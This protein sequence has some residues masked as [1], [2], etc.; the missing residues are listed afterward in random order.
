MN[1]SCSNKKQFFTVP[2]NPGLFRTKRWKSPNGGD[3]Q[4]NVQRL[5]KRIE[6][7]STTICLAQNFYLDKNR[8]TNQIS[9]CCI[10]LNTDVQRLLFAYPENNVGIWLVIMFLSRKK[11]HAKQLFFL[12]SSSMKLGPER[13]PT[14]IKLDVAF[15]KEIL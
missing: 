7:L 2:L 5:T 3:D 1:S 13:K 12:L 4:G 6:L 10:L 15:L 9:V 8:I 11:C 14:E